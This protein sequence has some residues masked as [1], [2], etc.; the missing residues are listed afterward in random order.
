M[1]APDH[2]TRINLIGGWLRSSDQKPLG[3]NHKPLRSRH[4]HYLGFT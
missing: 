1:L 4:I 3:K 2:E